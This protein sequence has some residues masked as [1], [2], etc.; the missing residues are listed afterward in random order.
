VAFYG[1]AF[2]AFVDGVQHGLGM[3]ALERIVLGTKLLILGVNFAPLVVVV[4]GGTDQPRT[5]RQRFAPA[6]EQRTEPSRLLHHAAQQVHAAGPLDAQ[7]KRRLRTA[8]V[9]KPK[10]THRAACQPVGQTPG[11]R[12]CGRQHFT[13]AD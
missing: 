2:L 4:Q 9:G 6:L 11:Q 13:A 1:Q 8:A 3:G 10:H 7:P 5:G 12:I